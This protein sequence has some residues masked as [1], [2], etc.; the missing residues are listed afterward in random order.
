MRRT[1]ARALAAC[2][3]C[4][5]TAS[6]FFVA[7]V[8]AWPVPLYFPLARRWAMTRRPLELSMDYYGRSLYALLGGIAAGLVVYACARRWLSRSPSESESPSVI[9]R[10][11]AAP[12]SGARTRPP[13]WGLWLA[14]LYALTALLLTAALFA[15]QLGGR[16]TFAE[17][18]APA[19]GPVAPPASPP[20]AAP[21]SGA[22]VPSPAG[23]APPAR[24]PQAAQAQAQAHDHDHDHDHDR[25]RDRDHDHDED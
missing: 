16:A 17:A 19:A 2:A 25:D 12:A 4:I 1:A 3:A 13:S 15:Y 18:L 7:S 5:G 8:A 23:D 11:P 24:D 10:E 20:T 9:G 6:S 22:I 14:L 21:A